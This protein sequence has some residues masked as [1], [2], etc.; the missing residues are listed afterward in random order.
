MKSQAVRRM[1]KWIGSAVLLAGLAYSVLALTSARPV[2][3]SSCNCGEERA[4][5]SDF[6][7]SRGGIVHFV[8]PVAAIRRRHPA[9][10]YLSDPRRELR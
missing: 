3:A 5:A 9:C 8:C 1:G 10:V 2:Y 6:C 4:E 7:Q